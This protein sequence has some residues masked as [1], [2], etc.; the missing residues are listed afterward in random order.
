M[1]LDELSA[2]LAV[3]PLLAARKDYQAAI[4]DENALGKTTLSTRRLSNQ[5]L[6]ELYGLDS[7]VAV[8][9][10]MRRL[11]DA[12][13]RSRPLL[14]LLCA[15]ARDPLL[16]GTVPAVVPLTEGQ[17]F[18]RVQARQTLREAV[19]PR[20]NDAILDKVLRNA[21]SSWTQSGHLEGRTFKK[22]RRVVPTPWTVAYAL[23][24]ARAVGFGGP[25]LFANGWMSVLDASP[26][27]ARALALEGKRLGL[28]DLSISGDIVDI[29]LNRL[30][31]SPASV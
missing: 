17:E 2:V 29:T 21:A 24:L 31:P 26:A 28:I 10:V 4:V 7:S 30:D 16:A 14:A 22:R 8:F 23:Y 25:D 11:W 19:G 5:R 1:M 6:G 12:D 27:D 13:Q 15:L 18:P 3:T 20:L 9:R